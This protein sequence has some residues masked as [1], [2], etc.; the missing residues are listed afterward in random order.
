MA[1]DAHFT[2]IVRRQLIGQV[3]VLRQVEPILII[4]A[5]DLRCGDHHS[6]RSLLLLFEIAIVYN[7]LVK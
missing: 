1:I 3:H 6:L 5:S 7:L 2:L 4:Y